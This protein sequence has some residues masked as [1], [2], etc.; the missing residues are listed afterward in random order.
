MQQNQRQ[1]SDIVVEV[2]KVPYK[3]GEMLD[4]RYVKTKHGNLFCTALDVAR[5][6]HG[7]IGQEQARVHLST[8]LSKLGYTRAE[9]LKDVLSTVIFYMIF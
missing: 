5:R 9:M 1:M 8:I 7:E 3:D 2:A 6:L 4:M